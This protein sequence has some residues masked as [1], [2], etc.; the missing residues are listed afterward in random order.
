MAP[1]ARLK[2]LPPLN[3]L[4]AFEAA[5]RNLH[6]SRAADEL[7]VTHG[8][9]SHQIRA[10]E[11]RLGTRLF[12]RRQ[13]RIALTEAGAR[14]LPV[15]RDAFDRIIR[16]TAD[17][18]R[19]S[20]A[21]ELRV[22]C[23]PG[24]AAQW[25]VPILGDFLDRHPEIAV[26]LSLIDPLSAAIEP[27]VDLAITYGEAVYPGRRV[28]LLSET[29]FFPVCSPALLRGQASLRRAE[30]IA[31]FALLHDDDGGAW[32]R[33]LAAA[34]VDAARPGRDLRFPNAA[35]ALDAAKAGLGFA[36][37]DEVLTALD[38]QS[39]A[40]LRPF[41]ETIAAPYT[42]YL[43]SGLDAERSPLC[44]AFEGW[45]ADR[46]RDLGRTAGGTRRVPA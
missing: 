1:M 24:F 37:G 32:A 20:M 28:T 41:R 42:Y 25:L 21:G 33:W 35:L 6:V 7:N 34:G 40:L 9:V 36:L 44:D 10:L 45:L 39:G 23:A 3:A 43:V 17:L 29:Q 8:A 30:A 38:L 27:G 14:L 26:A 46:I 19:P 31:P 15:V 16:A 5:G 11:D 4:R 13:R 18:E 12:D 22:A 2:H